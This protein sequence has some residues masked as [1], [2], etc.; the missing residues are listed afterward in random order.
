ME[1]TVYNTGYIGEGI[2]KPYVNRKPTKTYTAW[3]HMIRRCY[4]TLYQLKV[5]TY[6]GCTIAEEWHNYQV[7]AHWFE[8]NYIEG[9]Q[10][11]K[12][13]LV[14]NNKVYSPL[15]CCF[16][17]QEINKAIINKT[18]STLPIGVG[19]H[20]D[21]YRARLKMSSKDKCLGYFNTIEEATDSY[22][23][24]KENYIK[25]TA[26]KYKATITLQV[27]EA[28]IRYKVE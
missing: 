14:S 26:E 15:T 18:R 3:N 25:E 10:L 16:I 5:P 11:D 2:Y 8:N 23:K 24:A 20:R 9:Y 12:D 28:L 27:Y 7:F 4:D 6:I 13:L 22:K 1:K 19:K 17:P 21:K